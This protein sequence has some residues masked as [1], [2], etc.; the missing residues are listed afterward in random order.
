MLGGVHRQLKLQTETMSLAV[1]H[2]PSG[3]S[4]S[5]AN[6]FCKQS[7]LTRA[8]VTSMESQEAESS[9]LPPTNKLN[10]MDDLNS[11]R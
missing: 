8:S 3:E 4:S 5:G 11:G 7:R 10:K 9:A 6:V 2:V 1:C